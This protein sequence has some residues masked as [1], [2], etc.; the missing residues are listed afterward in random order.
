MRGWLRLS[1]WIDRQQRRLARVVAW[2]LAVMVL[3]G[4]YNAVAR[5]V[6]RDVGLQ[7]SSN[8]L[9]ELQWYLFSLVFLLG[10]PYALRQ[11]AHVRVDVL[12][13]GL[14]ARGRHWI[15]LLGTLLFLLPFC[16][17]AI[18]ASFDFVVD[19][20]AQ[21]ELSN[22]PGGLPRYPLKLVVPISFALLAMQGVSE[23]IKR[24]ALLRGASETEVHL[25]EEHP[26][27]GEEGV[28]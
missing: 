13:A 6:E 15:D 23:A 28:V 9:L 16:G 1:L 26:P 19:S 27:P 25:D 14:P 2:L 22:D 18:V 21:H 17:F 11:G 7:L 24:V 4:A 20:W 3:V 12:Y 8:A 10:A 5:Y